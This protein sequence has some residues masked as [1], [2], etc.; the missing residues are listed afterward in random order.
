[1][2]IKAPKAKLLATFALS[3]Y[4]PSA[5]A[6]RPLMTHSARSLRTF[7]R[8]GKGARPTLPRPKF[9]QWLMAVFAQT[10]SL[11]PPHFTALRPSQNG[12]RSLTPHGHFACSTNVGK[13][14]RPTLPGP[15]SL[16]I[17]S[18][19]SS[20]S[21]WPSRLT[22]LRPSH[23]PPSFKP[24]RMR[25]PRQLHQRGQCARPTLLGPKKTAVAG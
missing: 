3:S 7:H 24:C 13:G 1:M 17:V 20:H 23:K 5:H 22:A 9:R 4:R 25:L 19:C 10:S 15:V 12:P 21:L 11:W 6:E 8:V 14:A 16:K 2:H 18:R